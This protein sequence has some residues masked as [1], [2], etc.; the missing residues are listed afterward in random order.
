MAGPFEGGNNSR[1]LLPFFLI[2][3]CFLAYPYPLAVSNWLKHGNRATF[4]SW[5]LR[6]CMD[7]CILSA[8]WTARER[9]FRLI[10]NGAGIISRINFVQVR[11]SYAC[12]IF[13][14]FNLLRG[15]VDLRTIHY[16]FPVVVPPSNAVLSVLQRKQVF[17]PVII[18]H[19]REYVRD[20]RQWIKLQKRGGCE[21]CRR[22][23]ER[24][25]NRSSSDSR[26]RRR[27]REMRPRWPLKGNCGRWCHERY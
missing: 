17:H 19:F 25:E 5:C 14:Y 16:L 18:I 12:V 11:V 15:F 1:A 4:E 8:R 23:R 27:Y 26:A 13:W 3:F 2:L 24:R 22:E 20:G 7:S 21:T 6:G 9:S 10:A